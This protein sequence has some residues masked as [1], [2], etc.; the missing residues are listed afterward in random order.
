ML[1]GLVLTA[2]LSS[3]NHILFSILWLLYLNIIH[4]QV[5]GSI[6]WKVNLNLVHLKGLRLIFASDS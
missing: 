4:G 1:P 6:N 3:I 5:H 2:F